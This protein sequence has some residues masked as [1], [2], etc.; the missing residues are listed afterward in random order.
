MDESTNFEN[1]L[2]GLKTLTEKY[3]AL[4]SKSRRLIT[5]LDDHTKQVVEHLDMVKNLLGI[6]E[7]HCSVPSRKTHT[8]LLP[9]SPHFLCQLRSQVSESTLPHLPR[10]CYQYIQDIYKLANE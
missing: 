5:N 7:P 1:T 4:L 8:L 2:A 10:E 6:S 9:L 3:N